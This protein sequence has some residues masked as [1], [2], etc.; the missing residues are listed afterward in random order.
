MPRPSRWIVPKL[1]GSKFVRRMADAGLVAAAR[2]RTRRLDR[3]D[4]AAVQEAQLLK[5]VRKAEGTAFGRLHSFDQIHTVADFQARVPLRD[6]EQFWE[7]YWKAAYPRL[8]NITWPGKIPYYA[9]SSGTTSGATKYI[10]ISRA[11]IQSNKKAAFTTMAFY[12]NA[13]PRHRLFTGKFFFLGGSTNLRKQADGSAAGDLSAIASKELRLAGRPY[14]FPPEELSYISDW[15]VKLGQLAERSLREPITAISGVPSWMLKLFDV[16][17]QVSGKKTIAEVWPHLRLVVHGGTK[18]DSFRNTFKAEIGSDEVQFCEVYPCSEGFIATEDP[19]YKMLRLVPDHGIFFEFIPAEELKDGKL[20]TDRPTRHTLAT[21]QP[22]VVYAVAL[23]NCAGM[24]A[25]LVGD[26]I[27]FESVNPPLLRFSGRTKNFL[28]AFGEHLIEEEVTKAVAAAAANSGVLTADLHVG[29]VFSTDPT[30]PGHH[31]YH[32]EF[33]G[34]PPADLGAFA[35]D[36]DAE[37]RR[38]NE[39]YDAHR[40][41]DLTML[42]PVVSVVPEGGFARWMAARGKMGGQNK[43]PL[44]D[45]DGKLTAAIAEW[46][47]SHTS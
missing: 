45:N 24:W 1:A 28:S 15:T 22:G 41:N 46:M 5:L 47:A 44:M 35:A 26:T 34:K 8:D 3:M 20:A 30:K 39:D 40:V 33:R 43:V 27:T 31:L 14:V 16:V 29:P 25:Y 32:I 38:L 42:M 12:R 17:K 10:P 18:F 4:A 21:V 2:V 36:V 11:M 13:F 23:S 19:R 6:Y 7:L 9:L 37:L